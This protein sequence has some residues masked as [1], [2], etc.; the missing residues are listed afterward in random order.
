MFHIFH[1]IEQCEESKFD[2]KIEYCH[3]KK[4]FFIFAEKQLV[5]NKL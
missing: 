2:I 4:V 1:I 3:L 5:T